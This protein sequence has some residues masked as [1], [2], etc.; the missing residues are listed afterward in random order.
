MIEFTVRLHSKVDPGGRGQ[1]QPTSFTEH[2]GRRVEV[3]GLD[4]ALHH[5]LVA[6][7]NTEDGTVSTLT[8]Q[9]HNDAEHAPDLAA[10]LSVRWDTPTAEVRAYVGDEQVAIARME[11]PLQ[12]GQTVR[13]GE[14]LFNVAEVSHPSRLDDGTTTGA[15]YQ[16]ADLM[17]I[18]GAPPVQD[19]G[20]SP[21]GVLLAGA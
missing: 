2:I 20:A 21:F 10:N 8:I 7:E 19:L 5:V 6:V 14:Q 9:T 3:T 12:P 17:P 11:A 15:D 13:L 16:R 18:L 1:F 4:P